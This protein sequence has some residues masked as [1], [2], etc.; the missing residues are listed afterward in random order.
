M[1]FVR[2]GSSFGAEHESN[3][4]F[5]KYEIETRPTVTANWVAKICYGRLERVLECSLP[6]SKELGSLAGKQRLLAVISPCKRTAGK[7]AALKIVTY[8]G[9]AD[10]IV[11]D[12]QAI[13]AVVGRVETRGRWY[14]VD[15]TGGLI[16]P[17][18]LQDDEEEGN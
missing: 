8:S 16:R 7:D 1:S 4:F 6:D 13:V 15:R 5:L 3:Q 18:F 12:L 9:L 17:E 11:T 14:L 2:V 10:P